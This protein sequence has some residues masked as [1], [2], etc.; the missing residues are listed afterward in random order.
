MIKSFITCNVSPLLH[1]NNNLLKQIYRFGLEFPRIALNL[2]DISLYFKVKWLE[3]T[4]KLTHQVSHKEYLYTVE[5]TNTSIFYWNFNLKL[6]EDIDDGEYAY[7]L[8][9]DEGN[10]C[11]R[12][13]IQI[14]DYVPEKT[15]YE[16]KKTYT[17]YNG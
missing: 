5:D 4:L 3:M 7:V 13:L 11:A 8:S 9:D 10:E 6:A 14:G 1:N 15:E 16:N 12:G 2:Y 17:I